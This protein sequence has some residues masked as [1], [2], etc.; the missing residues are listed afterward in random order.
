MESKNI[1]KLV[2]ELKRNMPKFSGTEEEKEIKTALYIYVELAK[3]K[4]FDERYYFGNSKMVR[5]T[6]REALLDSSNPDKIVGKRKILCITMT[7]L[8]KAVLAEFG[9]DSEIITEMTERNTIEHMTNILKLKSGKRLLADA[10]LDMYRV[11]TGLTLNNFG[12]KS[13][14]TN[15]FI[16]P[17]ELTKMLIEIGYINSISDYRDEKIEN[18]K[19]GIK[20]LDIKEA[21]GVI[22]NSPEIYEAA[23]LSSVEAYKYY[24]STLKTLLPDEIG[25]RIYQFLCSK[26]VEG[27]ETPYY[28]FGIY[29]TNRR[30]NVDTETYLYSQKEGRMLGCDLEKLSELEEK[31]LKIG[32][33]DAETASKI[34]KKAMKNFRTTQKESG[35]ESR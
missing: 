34:L 33:N 16:D 9:I 27:S 8:Y 20:G 15:D 23:K 19:K 13:E 32:R 14:Y 4:S 18:V 35:D 31:G 11:Q 10:Q 12:S 24:H 30:G 5:K 2:E 21:V 1:K 28:S 22:M 25:R 29:T 17:D 26:K 7:H 6:E 3:R